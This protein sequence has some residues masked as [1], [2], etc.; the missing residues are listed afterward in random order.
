HTAF[1]AA[2]L[3]V[4]GVI[5]TRGG[6]WG[7]AE[8]TEALVGHVFVHLALDAQA[9]GSPTKHRA[10]REQLFPALDLNVLR[11]GVPTRPPAGVNQMAP[12]PRTGC[13]DDQ[14]IVGE[15]VGFGGREAGGPV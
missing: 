4:P 7:V 15:Q 12:D 6:A 13:V 8:P 10:V 11:V 9:E 1:G 3:Q 14:L 5:E 2:G